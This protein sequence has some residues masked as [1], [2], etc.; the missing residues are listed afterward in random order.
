MLPKYPQMAK[1]TRPRLYDA[2][3]R[4]RLF[5]RLDEAIKHQIIWIAAP[6]GAGKT[7]LVASYLEARGLSGIWYQIDDGDT[8][9]AGFFH[10]LSLAIPR[11]NPHDIKP[12]LS[13]TPEY[14][15]G[16]PAYARGFFRNLYA[17][18]NPPFTLV[19]DN[20]QNLPA[21]SLVHN[22]LYEG[23]TQLPKQGM[24]FFIS[25]SDPPAVFVR[26][27]A[28]QNLEMI[29]WEELRLD[30]EEIR[31]MLHRQHAFSDQAIVALHNKTSGWVAGVVLMLQTRQADSQGAVDFD[32]NSPQ[33]IFDYFAAEIFNK[34]STERQA[35][36]Y[37]TSFLPHMTAEMAQAVSGEAQSG[38][39]LAELS[40]QHYF[41]N[42]RQQPN[43]T[44]FQFHGLFRE[45]LMTQA[46]AKLTPPQLAQVQHQAAQV[47]EQSGQIEQA[48]ALYDQAADWQ[49]ISRIVLQ[50]APTLIQHGRNQTLTHWI[51]ALPRD[52]ADQTPWLLF[53]L[54]V[55]RVHYSA[56][57]ARASLERA[58]A[59]FEEQQDYAGAMLSWSAIVDS[60]ALNVIVMQ[61]LDHWI[62][63]LTDRM[64]IFSSLP[65]DIQAR[66][67]SSMA[68]AL[69]LR[70]PQHPEHRA[71]TERALALTEHHSDLSLRVQTHFFACFYFIFR[72]DLARLEI[73]AGELKHLAALDAVSPAMKL[74]ALY[75]ELLQ[76]AAL[77]RLDE[78]IKIVAH[79]LQLAETSGVHLWDSL[80]MGVPVHLA[81]EQGNTK[82][83]QGY[84]AKME[85]LRD[86]TRPWDLSYYYLLAAWY[87]L[88]S[89]QPKHA[90]EHMSKG[91][92]L[93][94]E[95]GTPLIEALQHQGMM[96]ILYTHG[97][98]IQAAEHLAKMRDAAEQQNNPYL[99]LAT[100]LCIAQLA[101]ADPKADA[102]EN[103][104]AA[105]RQAFSLTREHDL[106]TR[107]ALW[108]W[109]PEELAKL[110]ARALD[111][112]I[113]PDTVRR[114][115]CACS[116][117]PPM[118]S[119]DCENWPWPVKIYTLGR[120]SVHHDNEP[121]SFKA[122]AQ[123]KPLELLKALVALHDQDARDLTQLL[124]PELSSE[125]AR[126]AL[127]VNLHRL[128][129]WLGNNEAVISEAGRVKLNPRCCWVD[130]WAIDRVINKIENAVQ[131]PQAA[132][133]SLAS[134]V[135]KM[136]D[137]Y[138]GDFL[139][140][141]SASWSLPPRERLHARF[142]RAVS[143]VGEYWEKGGQW[144][145]AVDCYERALEADPLPEKFYQRLM[146]CYQQQG[147]LSEARATYERCQRM[148]AASSGA[149]PSAATQAIYQSL[150][151]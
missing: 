36:L 125:A 13:L 39:I 146:A 23:L 71:W 63:W 140:G 102:L 5:K 101:F 151:P 8:D 46:R 15:G 86:E 93:V 139:G 95:S 64:K 4:D 68:S 54:G 52:F 22:L 21:E 77:E 29:G 100:H 17:R 40:H 76:H 18:L 51:S 144:R 138:R 9:P 60:Y 150:S 55:S 96:Q 104:N 3:S 74:L 120:F 147:L 127:D 70:Q 6:P 126:A 42:Q 108:L 142:V 67:A 65:T 141:L 28:N 83:A 31:G 135:K 12:L 112:G 111:E 41:I 62:Q 115:I 124:W 59:K 1:L 106:T 2:Y 53:W 24:V 134:L 103:G 89:D 85:Q 47:L 98:Y 113:E 87:G 137:W 20:Y 10:H 149:Q 94:Q 132:F 97:R 25:R 148:C 7:T 105:L 118:A 73:V 38:R 56:T 49:A 37:K 128:R 143:A 81:L 84:L 14:R 44:Q 119:L 79:A 123:H 130:V 58:L 82:V 116:L 34:T 16:L 133:E 11:A 43:G 78:T 69:H 99:W 131:A 32:R 136:F 26:L 19:F 80:F 110:C 61:P 117:A 114:F 92:K 72:G 48:V 129:K 109:L 33:T 57:E 90:L 45:F 91:L 50:Q 30:H 88:L 121:L 27:R 66:V 122:K 145:Q 75:G 35:F 107:F